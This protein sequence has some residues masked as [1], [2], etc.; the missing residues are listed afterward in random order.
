MPCRIRPVPPA[1]R[2]KTGDPAET[3]RDS[4]GSAR[5]PPARRPCAARAPPVSPGH[6]GPV[7]DFT[8]PASIRA[9]L[10]D[11]DGVLVDHR[12]AADAASWQWARV[13]P[14]WELGPQETAERWEN[15]EIGRASCRERV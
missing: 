15:Y 2:W 12:S 11:I 6:T 10:L 5:A 8:V 7:P 13:L 14:G 1:A 4:A 9:I 3:G